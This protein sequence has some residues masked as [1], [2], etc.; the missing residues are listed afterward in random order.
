M[1]V[2]PRASEINAY[3]WLCSCFA[4]RTLVIITINTWNAMKEKSK[5]R[6]TDREKTP[7]IESVF[8]MT[9]CRSSLPS[10]L[11]NAR[12]QGRM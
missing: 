10:W 5:Q 9:V 1:R 12:P 2:K 4:M 8:A 6:R 7:E 11:L 3:L